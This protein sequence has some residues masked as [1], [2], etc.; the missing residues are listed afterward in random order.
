M[1]AETLLL[2]LSKVRKASRDRWQACCPAHEDKGPSLAIRELD[3]GRVLIHCF[4]GCSPVEILDAIGLRMDDLF[5]PRPADHRC[6]RERRAFPASDVLQC[7][8]YESV[9]IYQFAL[10]LSRGEPLTENAKQRL[11][12]AVS[13]F[14]HG[15]EVINA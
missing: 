3:D 6:K 9:L 7:L 14:Q 1:T 15:A 13:R 4:A 10:L 8:A 5:P 12:V 2:R 11:L